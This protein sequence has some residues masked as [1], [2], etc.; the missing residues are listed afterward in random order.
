MPC[1]KCTG[2]G[3]DVYFLGIV[4][5][6]GVRDRSTPGAISIADL[7]PSLADVDHFTDDRIDFF[8]PAS[9][10]KHAVMSDTGLHVV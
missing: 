9:S 8:V 1:L 5:T 10:A 3:N 2:Y 6:P 4:L 7:H